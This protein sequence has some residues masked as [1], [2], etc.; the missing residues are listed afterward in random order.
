VHARP[1]P[2]PPEPLLVLGLLEQP[3]IVNEKATEAT[4]NVEEEKTSVERVRM[5]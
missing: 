4:R 2:A 3:T 5:K 1:E